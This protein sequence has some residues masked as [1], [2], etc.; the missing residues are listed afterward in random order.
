MR[1]DQV[2]RDRTAPCRIGHAQ[3]EQGLDVPRRGIG[4][5]AVEQE[6]GTFLTDRHCS[7][8]KLMTRVSD[9]KREQMVNGA[10]T[11]NFICG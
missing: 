10:T 7:S 3:L 8:P 5:P 4:K 2:D 9:G 11:L 1:L 6:V